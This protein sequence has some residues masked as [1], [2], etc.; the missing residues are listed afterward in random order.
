VRGARPRPTQRLDLSHHLLTLIVS[1]EEAEVAAARLWD[2]GAVGIEETRS[3]LRAAFIAVE[4]A[5][6]AAHL[7]GFVAD[8][9]TVDDNVG[10]DAGRDMLAA[11]E[12]GRFVVHPPWIDPPTGGVA[13]SIDPGHAFGSGS[14]ASTRLAL[15]LLG[16][17]SE[18]EHGLDGAVVIDIGCGTGILSIAAA[19]L[20]ASV[21]ALDTD[22]AAIVAT[23]ANAEAN[24][25]AEAITAE[26][27]SVADLS[28]R[29]PAELVLANVTIDI[30][31]TLG[32]LLPWQPD[33]LIAAGI[34]V[35]SQAP[36]CAAAWGLRVARE[37][38]DGEWAGLI[39][40]P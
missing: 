13:L 28:S 22:P 7:L 26:L 23:T 37:L 27:G 15:M 19:Q 21:L 5:R 14:H 34:L 9:E 35:G 11:V 18:R 6:R 12:A 39:L 30:H 2:L 36:R 16:E 31:E 29:P 3:G 10:M 17:I 1:P 33:R 25:V 20:G 40:A 24:D 4:P 32:P 8:I 38:V